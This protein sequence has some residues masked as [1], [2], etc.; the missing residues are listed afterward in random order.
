MAADD[1]A[2]AN[3]FRA[4]LEAAVRTGDLEGVY[5]LLAPDVEWVTPQRT[6]SGIDEVR[7]QLNWITPSELF[8]Y[9]F[10]EGEWV[11]QGDG[12]LVCLVHEV[13][14]MKE[15]GDVGYE[16]DRRVELTIRGGEISRYEMQNVAG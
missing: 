1:V 5:P 3:R 7:G 4:A 6:L 9:E 8:D 11:D 13:Y 14:R 16:R 12:R 15:S 10:G 2:I